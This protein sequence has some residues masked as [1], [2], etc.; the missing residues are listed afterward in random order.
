M[1]LYV[2]WRNKTCVFFST[3]WHQLY[4]QVFSAHS[5]DPCG[6]SLDIKNCPPKIPSSTFFTNRFTLMPIYPIFLF[7]RLI[8]RY[9]VQH[10]TL[11]LLVLSFRV[12]LSCYRLQLLIKGVMILVEVQG[13]IFFSSLDCWPCFYCLPMSWNLTHKLMSQVPRI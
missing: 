7:D 10:C 6:L 8:P 1:L 4:D 12:H 5:V 2:G 3:Q 9:W 13:L 11:Q